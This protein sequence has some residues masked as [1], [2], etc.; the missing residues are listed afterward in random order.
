VRV[1]RCVKC[2][3]RHRRVDRP[4]ILSEVRAFEDE[5]RL[6]FICNPR[7]RRSRRWPCLEIVESQLMGTREVQIGT[8]RGKELLERQL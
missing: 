5:C 1:R 8:A 3:T 6:P 2:R 7:V 4:R